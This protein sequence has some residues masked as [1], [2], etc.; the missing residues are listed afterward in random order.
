MNCGNDLNT[1]LASKIC[2]KC[3]TSKQLADFPKKDKLKYKSFCRD[4]WNLSRR[5]NHSNCRIFNPT[6]EIRIE[7]SQLKSDWPAVLYEILK[8]HLIDP[9]KVN[10]EDINL[11]DLMKPSCRISD[12]TGT[13][14]VRDRDRAKKQEPK[15]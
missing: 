3:G 14:T 11:N 2:S 7:L 1:N 15:R 12:L 6:Y 9:K 8:D 13:H 10:S 4:C 5:R